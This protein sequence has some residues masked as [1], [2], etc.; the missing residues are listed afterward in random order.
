MRWY[1]WTILGFG[2]WLVIAPWV[3]GYSEV[4]LASW[5]SILVGGLV[6]V[7]ALWNFS[8]TAPNE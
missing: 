7:F 5:N 8:P 3:L 1:H 2:V 4:N 6:I